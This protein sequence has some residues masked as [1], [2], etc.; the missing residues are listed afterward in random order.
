MFV[1]IDFLCI[2]GYLCRYRFSLYYRVCSWFNCN[3]VE[4]G[5]KHHKPNKLK[6]INQVKWQSNCQIEYILC[7]C[8]I[9]SFSKWALD[10]HTI[11]KLSE[12]FFIFFSKTAEDYWQ[13]C[14]RAWP[15]H[16]SRHCSNSRIVTLRNLFHFSML[17]CYK[18]KMRIIIF[19]LL[20][21]FSPWYSWERKKR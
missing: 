4:S 13:K 20:R 3:I 12:F 19:C 14:Y 1:D 17:A 9:E 5:I 15:L 11:A 6:K 2:T 8:A 10:P 18:Y 7:T 21:F 16:T